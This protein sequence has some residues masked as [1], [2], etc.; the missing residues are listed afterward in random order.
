MGDTYLPHPMQR[1]C[2]RIPK[3][4]QAHT[5]CC[6]GASV[7]GGEAAPYALRLAKCCV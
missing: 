2:A 4:C 5:V 7:V 6:R 3:Q 1:A